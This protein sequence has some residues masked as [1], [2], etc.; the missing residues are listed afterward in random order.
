MSQ[1]SRWIEF[2]TSTPGVSYQSTIL[3]AHMRYNQDTGAIIKHVTSHPF[4]GDASNKV[5][6]L[7][8][9]G[10]RYIYRNIVP[11]VLRARWM[12]GQGTIS[13]T[14]FLVYLDAQ[15]MEHG[16]RT[17][18]RARDHYTSGTLIGGEGGTCPSSL[19][20]TLEGPTEYVNARWM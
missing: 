5:F 17:R 9:G 14:L 7:V 20:I 8:N 1:K 4:F 16:S 18:L 15:N 6:L 19:H 3:A 10:S 13:G 11:C 2:Q 12:A